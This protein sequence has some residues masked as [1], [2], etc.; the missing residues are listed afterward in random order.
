MQVYPERN[1][2]SRAGSLTLST[3]SLNLGHDRMMLSEAR[4]N[5]SFNVNLIRYH[6]RYMLLKYERLRFPLKSTD[7]IAAWDWLAE[8]VPVSSHCQDGNKQSRA[9]GKAARA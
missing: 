1:T 5:A 2:K 3:T 7:S 8:L 4:S 9:A 6:S